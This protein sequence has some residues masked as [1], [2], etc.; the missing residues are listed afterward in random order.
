[1]KKLILSILFVICLSFQASAW[2]PMVVVSGSGNPCPPF[3]ADSGVVWSWDGNYP[4]SHNT[5]CDSA[6][7]PDVADTDAATTAAAY[8]ETGIGMLVEN[9]QE[10]LQWNQTAQQY[11]DETSAQTICVR[12]KVSPTIVDYTGIFKSANVSDQILITIKDDG[13][14]I[15]YYSVTTGTDQT[16]YGA[17]APD[18]AWFTGAYSFDKP[19]LDHASNP[20]DNGTWGSGWD[21][22]VNELNDAMTNDLDDITIGNNST[23]DPAEGDY[24]YID[25]I[26]I[27]NG[28]KF[29]CSTLTGW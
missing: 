5:A 23:A 13:S 3:Y 27:V 6:G 16:V 12:M 4:G 2:N 22:Q 21:E 1:M 15:G 28:Y 7:N 18:S 25:K 24:V 19:N 14:L 17:T 10:Y 29:D 26:A 20:G 8:G 11:L 9:A